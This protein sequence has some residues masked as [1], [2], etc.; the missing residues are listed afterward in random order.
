MRTN[1]VLD[2]DLVDEALTLTGAKT[3]SELVRLAIVELIRTRKRKN[4][5]D[6]AGQIQFRDDFDHKKDRELRDGAD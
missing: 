6:L 3:K 4:L 2:D 5:L 1:I